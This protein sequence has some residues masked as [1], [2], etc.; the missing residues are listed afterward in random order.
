MLCG[1][2]VRSLLK[3]PEIVKWGA[4]CQE[5]ITFIKKKLIHFPIVIALAML[6]LT[7]VRR[8]SVFYYSER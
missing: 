2:D 1:V 7:I 6:M 3:P 5:D 4:R 8:F